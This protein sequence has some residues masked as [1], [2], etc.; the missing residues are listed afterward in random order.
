[1]YTDTRTIL[2]T[3][4]SRGIGMALCDQFLDAGH[5]VIACHRRLGSADAVELSQ[6]R[7]ERLVVL[8]LDVTAPESVLRL[9]GEL[10]RREIHA[11]DVLINNAGVLAN[12]SGGLLTTTDAEVL[13]CFDVNV[14]GTVRV[15]RALIPLLL[16]SPRGTI[17]NIGSRAASLALT[18]AAADQYGYRMSKC[19]LN[20]LTRLICLEFPSLV[21]TA[22]HPGWIKTDIGGPHA[23]LELN[24]VVPILG[25]L[26]LALRLEQSGKFLTHSGDHIPW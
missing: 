16:N 5:R 4:A 19:A 9:V 22:I 21:A 2:I 17:A 7:T 23:S 8:E 11:I 1:M 3:G 12:R 24:D 26:I 18:T 25:N 20:M 14:L 13:E 10:E 6:A 15:T